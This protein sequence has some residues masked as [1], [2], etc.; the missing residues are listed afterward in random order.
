MFA[1]AGYADI[2]G[3]GDSVIAIEK[4]IETSAV[5]AE[6]DGTRIAVVT[7]QQFV[8]ANAGHAGIRCTW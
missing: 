6:V 2:Q 8:L 5:L 1:N 3:T 7:V 4:L